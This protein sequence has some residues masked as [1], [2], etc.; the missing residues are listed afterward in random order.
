M[1]LWRLVD[2]SPIEKI[3]PKTPKIG[4]LE[5]EFDI[6]WRITLQR[7]FTLTEKG[8]S[9]HLQAPNTVMCNFCAHL[10]LLSHFDRLAMYLPQWYILSTRLNAYVIKC[11]HPSLDL[12]ASII[13]PL[14]W[15]LVAVIRE[16]WLDLSQLF[17]NLTITKT[18]QCIVHSRILLL[19]VLV[20]LNVSVKSL[21]KQI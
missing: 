2:L 5:T 13:L 17:Y 6:R 16:F 20:V 3:N 15:A 12:V 14:W 4:I 7:N 10:A 11:F 21:Q 1:H 8:R 9:A 18:V 19:E